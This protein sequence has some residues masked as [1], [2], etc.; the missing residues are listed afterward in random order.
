MIEYESNEFKKGEKLYLTLV[1]EIEREDYYGE[2]YVSQT[3]KDNKGRFHKLKK[4]LFQQDEQEKIGDLIEVSVAVIYPDFSPKI[5]YLGKPDSHFIELSNFSKVV[6]TTFNEIVSYLSDDDEFNI[7]NQYKSK[8][9]NW[10]WTFLTHIKKLQE[11]N[12]SNDDFDGFKNLQLIQLEIAETI[13]RGKFLLEFREDKR[14]LIKERLDKII[15]RSSSILELIDNVINPEEDIKEK[16]FISLIDQ[17]PVQ[18]GNELSLSNKLS[19]YKIKFIFSKVDHFFSNNL[20]EKVLTN[21]LAFDTQNNNLKIQVNE[22]SSKRRKRIRS[23]VFYEDVYNPKIRKTLHLKKNS[24]LKHLIALTEFDYQAYSLRE[25]DNGLSAILKATL[26]RFQGYFYND[27]KYIEESINYLYEIIGKDSLIEDDYSRKQW[28]F[29]FNFELA[30]CYRFLGKNSSSLDKTIKFY[31]SALVYS[32]ETRSR[33]QLSDEGFVKYFEM[34]QAIDRKESLQTIKNISKEN[35]T[36]Y[37]EMM[38]KP[39]T[40]EFIS[41][42]SFLSQLID[43]YKILN[44]IK[45]TNNLSDNYKARENM[46]KLFDFAMEKYTMVESITESKVDE[47]QKNDR[48]Y[49]SEIAA[50][51]LA[52]NLIGDVNHDL[53]KVQLSKVFSKGVVEVQKISSNEV[54]VDSDEYK[55]IQLINLISK[56]E[57]QTLEFKG[58]WNLSIDLY[59]LPK[60]KRKEHENKWWNQS[61][62][63]SRAVASMLN[64]NKGGK[65]YIG[66]LENKKKYRSKNFR[67]ALNE[68][69]NCEDLKGS[70]NVLVGIESEIKAKGWDSDLLIQ[71]INNQLKVDIHESVIQHCIIKSR[72]VKGKEIIEIN[73]SEN[74]FINSGWWIKDE[75]LPIRENN[76][77]NT[78]KGGTANRWLSSQSEKYA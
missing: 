25:D 67:D 4:P 35:L 30:Q 55:E 11:D 28:R 40:E 1:R 26:M 54:D 53:L 14:S 33:N 38:K 8:N 16:Y 49:N 68:R 43:M 36:L 18:G 73:I 60:E 13:K 44:L 46:F 34:A 27:T 74:S 62:E 52:S 31:Q 63:V 5:V 45:F 51:V 10:I 59:I 69:M 77:I 7:N 29:S 19:N 17:W 50:L 23:E 41:N 39:S 78:L 58:S 75:E 3:L 37:Q 9:G 70:G 6:K 57:S 15:N 47:N 22:W 66:I 2:T 61:S 72:L 32:T 21:V 20:I 76:Q 12:L 56:N 71:N 24:Q 48:I 65:L 42:S 64:A